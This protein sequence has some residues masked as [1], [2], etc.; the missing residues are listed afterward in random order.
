MNSPRLTRRYAASR[1]LICALFCLGSACS[2]QPVNNSNPWGFGAIAGNAG[3]A[4][5]QNTATAPVHAGSG[6]AFSASGAGGF[7]AQNTGADATAPGLQTC[8]DVSVS[9]SRATPWVLFVI[10][11]SSSMNGSYGGSASRWQAIYDTLMAPNQGVIATLENAAWFG[12]LIY[13]GAEPCPTFPTV[14]PALNNY[15]AIDAVYRTA[16]TSQGTPTADALTAAYKMVPDQKQMLDF[17]GLKNQIVVLC[18]DG[19]PNSCAGGRD[20]FNTVTT[21][22]YAASVTAVTS[23]ATAGI[24]TYVISVASD[25]GTEYQNFLDQLAEIGNP[26]TKSFSPATKDDLAAKIKEI[27][28]Q[29]LTCEIELKG[30][31]TAAGACRGT[32]TLNSQKLECDGA[33]GWRLKDE[34]HIELQGTACTSLKDN[35]QVQL[36]ATFPCDVVE[37]Q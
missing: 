26:G 18:T 24:K 8:A 4:Q 22:P 36:S 10:D 29:A 3:S 7:Q 32:V 11:G 17:P 16:Q 21:D 19:Q 30:T 13:N 9:V 28:G 33:D 6:A 25:E 31:V 35:A 12:M 23:A 15:K 37:I 5:A 1:V 34:T 14:A 20:F 27:V 2:P